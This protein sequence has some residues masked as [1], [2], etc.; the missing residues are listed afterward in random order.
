M[1]RNHNLVLLNAV[2]SKYNSV[3]DSKP[4]TDAN[5]NNRFLSAEQQAFLRCSTVYTTAEE[6]QPEFLKVM[7]E[8]RTEDAEYEN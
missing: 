5:I 2:I 4:F 6:Q 7:S 1:N 8:I 3:K